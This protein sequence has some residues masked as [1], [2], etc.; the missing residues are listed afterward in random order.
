MSK[1]KVSFES[2]VLKQEFAVSK[3][4]TNKKYYYI[5]CVIAAVVLI[6][7]VGIYFYMQKDSLSV[8]WYAYGK[9]LATIETTYDDHDRV[10]VSIGDDTVITKKEYYKLKI[11]NDYTFNALLEEYNKYVEKHA[12]TL[13]DEEKNELKPVRATD[14]EIVESLIDIEIGYLEAMASDVHMSY[15]VAYS[16]VNA[17]Y[18][19]YKNIMEEYS[20]EDELYINAKESI[21]QMEAVASGMDCT[22]DEY[23]EY[24]AEDSI[25]KLACSLLEERWQTEFKSTD[26]DGTVDDYLVYKYA[27]ARK[28]YNIID[29][30]LEN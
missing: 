20:S 8:D 24:L 13:T 4:A 30:G 12:D 21:E 9:A 19:T 1:K 27:E 25:K 16:Q 28:K 18:L 3:T 15:A 2:D 10:I 23:I 5:I 6:A 17:T 29:H 22:L 26:F 14:E 11:L 7:M